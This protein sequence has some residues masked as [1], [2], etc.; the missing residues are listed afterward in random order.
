MPLKYN[1]EKIY[2][3]IGSCKSSESYKGC[4][5]HYNNT[6]LDKNRVS[7]QDLLKIQGIRTL[8]LDPT[9]GNDHLSTNIANFITILLKNK[10][11]VC[12]GKST[13]YEEDD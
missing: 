4:I 2:K 7:K 9:G 11:A 3:Y 1:E 10:L 12:G 13:E 5:I 8:F 6:N